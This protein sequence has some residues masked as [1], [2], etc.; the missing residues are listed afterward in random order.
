MRFQVLGP[1]EIETD[2]GPVTLGG[3]KERL[4]LACC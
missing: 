4:L 3:Q 2:N 1:P